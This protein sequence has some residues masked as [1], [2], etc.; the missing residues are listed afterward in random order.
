MCLFCFQYSG[1]RNPNF[2][3]FFPDT[4]GFCHCGDASAWSQ[5]PTCFEHQSSHDTVTT[6]AEVYLTQKGH[7]EEKDTI[8]HEINITPLG[9]DTDPGKLWTAINNIKMDGLTWGESERAP[10]SHGCT[11]LKINCTITNPNLSIEDV[12]EEIE[13]LEDLV[14]ITYIMTDDMYEEEDSMNM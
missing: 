4:G 9:P 8:S 3:K 14:S 6:T 10:M 5:H 1:H 7:N 12:Q 11:M 2:K 13:A